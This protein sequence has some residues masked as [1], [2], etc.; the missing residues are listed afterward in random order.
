MKTTKT[1]LLA[2]TLS[3]GLLA[4]TAAN[5]TLVSALGGQVVNDTDLNITWLADANYAKN[6][7]LRRGWPDELNQAQGWIAS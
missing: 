5:A 4:A 2:A 7:R 3:A 6:Q 1:L